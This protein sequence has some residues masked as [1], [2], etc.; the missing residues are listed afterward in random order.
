MEPVMIIGIAILMG[1]IILASIFEILAIEVE[2]RRWAKVEI[3]VERAAVTSLKP[4]SPKVR[5]MRNDYLLD[6]H[7]GRGLMVASR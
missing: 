7:F 1:G 3:E 4:W 2:N 5:N 6:L